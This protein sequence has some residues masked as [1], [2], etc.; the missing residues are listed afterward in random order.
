M[1][2]ILPIYELFNFF[3]QRSS[4]AVTALHGGG[5]GGWG[6]GELHIV[7]G[8]ISIDHTVHCKETPIYVFPEKELRD[9]SRNFHIPVSV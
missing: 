6:G 3:T 5:G 9:I 2:D 1:K 8:R 7:L 4:V